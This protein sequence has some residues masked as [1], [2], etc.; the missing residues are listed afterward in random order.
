MTERVLRSGAAAEHF[1][2]MVKE[3]GGPADFVNNYHT[4]CK[5]A[6]VVVPV[7]T[8][9]QGYIRQ[10]NTRAVGLC[11]VEL[12]GG[13]RVA[14]DSVDHAVGLTEL[15]PLGTRM[16]VGDPICLVHARTKDDANRAEK[17]IRN[18]FQFS[19]SAG[20]Q[21]VSILDRIA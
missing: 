8:E 13:R 21:P 15:A 1:G 5:S 18:A 3:L 17:L 12:G 2:R 11:V 7:S 19:D 16:D 14:S 6:P 20:E 9:T 10:I 4:H